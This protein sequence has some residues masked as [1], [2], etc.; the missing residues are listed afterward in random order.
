MN[1]FFLKKHHP[2]PPCRFAW[3]FEGKLT[4]FTIRVFRSSILLGE[5][6]VSFLKISTI[7]AQVDKIC[8][9]ILWTLSHWQTCIGW[10]CNPQLLQP[11]F[12]T[13][14][15]TSP[16]LFSYNDIVTKNFSAT[17][18]KEKYVGNP[19]HIHLIEIIMQTFSVGIPSWM[20]L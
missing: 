15:R 16:L 3:K 1:A 11:W 10:Y 17:Y 19:L 2:P 4:K 6:F 14:F 18:V 9:R 5:I 7:N 8:F 20:G 13:I 12:S